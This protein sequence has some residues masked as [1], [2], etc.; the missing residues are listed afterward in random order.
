MRSHGVVPC[1]LACALSG[2]FTSELVG[3]PPSAAELAR[4]NDA[5]E[6]GRAL[7]V[8]YS[9]KADLPR[10]K[11]PAPGT[12][13]AGWCPSPPVE[14]LCS[15]SACAQLPP[16]FEHP[17]RVRSA[18]AFKLEL[19]LKNGAPASLP[20]DWVDGLEVTGYGHARGTIIG[21][22]I[23][24]GVTA[25]TL[26]VLVLALEGPNGDPIVP[27]QPHGCDA[28]CGG[29]FALLTLQGALLGGIIGA[30]V[31]TPHEFKLAPP[32]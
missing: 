24:T 26:L 11:K 2:C 15:T 14:P 5:A 4:I 3:R 27:G 7:V 28:K 31:G 18:D 13:V 25:S 9:K 22:S 21:A 12:C 8:E 6:D 19:S 10:P 16:G 1:A 32:P 20:L 30:A 17:A 23:G 29:L